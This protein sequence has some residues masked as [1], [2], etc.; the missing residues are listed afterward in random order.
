MLS[1]EDWVGRRLVA[2]RFRDGRVFICGDAAHVWVPYAGYGMNAGIADAENLGWLLAARLQG[3][4]PRVDA[5]CLRAERQPITEQVS[6]FAMGH[7]E[8]MIRKRGSV[9]PEIEDDTPG[10]RSCPRRASARPPTSST[11]SNT[12][13]PGSTSATST[14]A[15]R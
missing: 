7:A 5:G 13:R 4:A 8:G 12:A 9:P 10:G 15:R 3:W 6:H 11:S 2:D 14:T 1:K